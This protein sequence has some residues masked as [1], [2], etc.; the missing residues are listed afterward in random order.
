MRFVNSDRETDS[1]WHGACLSLA[2]LGR[3]GLLLPHRLSQVSP[4]SH[5][6][7]GP[8]AILHAFSLIPYLRIDCESS[9]QGGRQY[10]VQSFFHRQSRYKSAIAFGPIIFFFPNAIIDREN[11]C[12]KN[13]V[14]LSHLASTCSFQS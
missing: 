1:G 10:L 4:F 14:L 8:S 6:L 2:E 5:R 9:M 12:Q 11:F 13:V 7:R 3:R